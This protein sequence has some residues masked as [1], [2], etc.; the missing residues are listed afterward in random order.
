M[1]GGT[2]RAC[3]R[4]R[5]RAASG[6][7]RGLAAKALV[8]ALLIAALC[9]AVD[10]DEAAA[11]L[12]RARP[13]P[14][15]TA[16]AASVLGVLVS[17]EK[18]RGLLLAAGVRLSLAACA[19]LYWV[20]MFASNLLPTSVGGDAA[21]LMLTPAPGRRAAVAGSI[22]VERL[23]GFLVMLGL[24]TLGLALRPAYFDAPGLRNAFLA[25]VLA[26]D[27]GVVA[28]LL[29]PGLLVPPLARLAG[30]LPPGGIPGR[31][32][33]AAG[34]VAAA[35]AAQA[36]DPAALAR[37][38]GFS[39]LF[40]GTIIV[41][42]HA[43]LRAAGADVS[44]LEVALV[45]AVVPLIAM[46]PVSL[47]GLGVAEGVF[48]LLYI[49]LGVDPGAALAAAVL[50]RLVDL[51]NSGLGGPLWLAFRAGPAAGRSRTEAGLTSGTAT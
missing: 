41:A 16:L 19:R 37:A 20:G 47:N 3:L 12:A 5:D 48:V 33:A 18:W 35:V 2:A 32:V 11:A 21:R 40:Y 23:T 22:L 4:G 51:A 15:A 27:L 28:A 17:A 43:V 44:L 24:C 42:Q 34:R 29:A 6:P 49:Q 31:A 13:L 1:R 50:R 30:R 39:V 46:A 25:A 45:A 7:H 36:R 8:A 10:L 26:L 38:L 14:L 9:L